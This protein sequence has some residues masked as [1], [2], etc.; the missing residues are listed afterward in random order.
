MKPNLSRNYFY[1][2]LTILVGIV[3]LLFQKRYITISGQTMGTTYL[4]TVKLPYWRLTSIV[5][6]VV[7]DEL[8]LLVDSMSTYQESSEISKLNQATAQSFKV[9]EGFYAVLKLSQDIYQ[10]SGGAWDPTVYPL[11]SLWKA[12]LYQESDQVPTNKVIQEKRKHIG[13]N[14]LE[15]LSNLTVKKKDPL[16]QVDVSSIAKGYGVD[17][18]S[19]RFSEWGSKDYLVEIGG[20]VKISGRNAYGHPWRL[21]IESPDPLNPSLY[22]KINLPSGYAIA[23]SGS[24]RQYRYISGIRYSH[25]IDPRTGYPVTH[26]VVGV[27]VVSTDCALADALATALM[28][29]GVEEGRT[30]VAQYPQTSALFFVQN[31]RGEIEVIKTEGFPEVAHF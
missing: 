6:K 29:M 20:E 5:K 18:I 22:G 24:Y 28:V 15:L 10:R 17:K 4:V 31:G 11:F 3:F 7:E 9:S 27:S 14:Q 2:V 1:V 8:F 21:G 16:I 12:V 23:S 25:I 30:L 13:L 26:N 19:Q